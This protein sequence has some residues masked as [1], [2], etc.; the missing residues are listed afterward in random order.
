M[1]MRFDLSPQMKLSQIIAPRMI[2]SMEILQLPVMA[3]QE[4]IQTE[5]QENPFL[6]EKEGRA[7][8][9]ETV[10]EPDFNPDAPLKH[11]ET[12]DLE[13]AR[14]DEINKDWGDHFNE[15][16][17][18]SRA[19]LEEQSDKKLE[20]MM[21]IASAPESLQDH[22]TNQLAFLDLTPDQF[23][24]AEFVISHLDDNGYLLSHD[25]DSG[26]PVPV[27]FEDLARNF[28]KPVTL[29]DVED[30]LSFVQKLDPAGVGA[31]DTKE[32]LLLQVTPETPHADLVRG[33][34]LHHLEDV[35]HNRLPV[36]QKKCGADLATIKDAIEHLKC[37]DPKPGARFAAESAKY[38]VPDIIVT[39]TDDDDFV[40]KL[41][42][43]WTPRVR[44]SKRY[45]ELLKDKSY[46]PKTREELQKKFRSA[47]WLIDAIEQRRNTLIKVT[48]AIITHQR[49]FLDKGPE[50]IL[51]LKM[52]QIADQVGVH[53]TTVSRAVDD[54]WVETPRGVF[55]LKR[56]FGGG[57]KNQQTGENVAW[58]TIKQ[59]LLEIIA[60]EDKAHP[61]SDEEIMDKFKIAGLTVARRTVTKYREALNIPSSR[62]R[63]DWTLQT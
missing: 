7:T 20:A 43:E 44:V 36:I 60:E 28:G 11:D 48:R 9:P 17:R 6:E 49:A 13:F 26:K 33:L 18:P 31:R 37:L 10:A 62:Q 23:E 56:F 5:L 29:A 39:R 27:S 50:F 4:K 61:Y 12:G 22:L 41:T 15:E 46:D 2:Q 47:H 51:P 63:K 57:T 21:N 45:V 1:H 25:A 59:K 8:E 14:M 19:S 34:I 30:A 24:L 35:A 32:C 54:K 3:L 53:V 52:E 55:S 42:D 16:H 40:I 58:E 38:V